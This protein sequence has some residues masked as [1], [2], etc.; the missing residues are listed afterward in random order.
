MGCDRCWKGRL[1]RNNMN[2]HRWRVSEKFVDSIQ[3]KI[4]L[5]AFYRGMPKHNLR[6]VFFPDK[7]SHGLGYCR[8][9]QL[10]HLGAHRFGKANVGGQRPLVG[11]LVIHSDID[12]DDV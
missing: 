8:R 1:L 10:D 4:P 3:V 7:S 5:P 9:F 6:D 12:V 11:L 2:I